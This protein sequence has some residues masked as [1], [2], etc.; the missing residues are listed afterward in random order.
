MNIFTANQVNQV[1]VVTSLESSSTAGVTN[2]GEIFVGYTD[3]HEDIFFVHKGKGGITRSDLIPVKNIMYCKSTDAAKTRQKLMTALVSVNSAALTSGKTFAGQ[4]YIL[5]LE[6]QNPI[7]MSPDNKYLVFGAVHGTST[8]TESQFYQKMIEVLSKNAKNVLNDT[9]TIEYG[10]TYT[11]GGYTIKV[12]NPED[13]FK[14]ATGAATT[15]LAATYSSKTLTITPSST[16]SD[17]TVSELQTII[18]ALTL[19]TGTKIEVLSVD[20]TTAASASAVTAATAKTGILIS[21]KETSWIRGI[22]QQKP[23]I[24]NV[25]PSTIVTDQYGTEC[26]WSDV[27]YSSGKKVTGGSEVTESTDATNA[28]APVEIANGKLMADF[29][30]FYMGE[31]GDQYRMKTWPDY[32]PTEYMVDPSHEYDVVSIHFAYTGSNHAVQKSEK[33]ITLLIDTSASGVR[34]GLITAIKTA[35]NDSTLF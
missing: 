20:A 32:V 2:E 21:G 16:A 6:M 4:D 28:P 34:S 22:K 31:R 14:I 3:N 27:I 33:D 30:Y 23:V 5:N 26:Y 19:P 29:E 8:M 18:D 25:F 17:D 12:T 1:Y 9:L 35:A 11:M 24:F 13:G 7:G 10:N 15:N